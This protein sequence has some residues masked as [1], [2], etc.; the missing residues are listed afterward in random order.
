MKLHNHLKWRNWLHTINIIASYF[1]ILTK[2]WFNKQHFKN[3]KGLNKWTEYLFILNILC[4]YFS[5]KKLLDFDLETGVEYSRYL[6]QFAEAVL[7]PENKVSIFMNKMWWCIERTLTEIM[8]YVV[9]YILLWIV[10]VSIHMADRA[11]TQHFLMAS[12]HGWPCMKT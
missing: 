12:A 7:I 2:L 6:E 4:E 11:H 5:S 3:L 1:V 9:H 10:T 8:Y